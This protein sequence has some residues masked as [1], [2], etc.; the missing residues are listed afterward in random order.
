[1]IK[2]IQNTKKNMECQR[3]FKDIDLNKEPQGS[4]LDDQDV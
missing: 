4:V 3:N 2:T 1:M